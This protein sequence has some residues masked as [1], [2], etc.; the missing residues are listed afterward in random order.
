M[1]RDASPLDAQ[2]VNEIQIASGRSEVDLVRLIADPA[3]H[4]LVAECDDRVGGWAAIHYLPRSDGPAGRGHYL[5]GVTVDP[6]ERRRGV[7]LALTRA[8]LDW[9]WKRADVAWYFVNAQNTV[10]IALHESLGFEL[11]GGS[12]G[13]HGGEFTGGLGL[14]FRADRP[15]E[16]PTP[17]EGR[18]R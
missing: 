8:R 11:V 7:G 6:A 15:R 9:I 2:R 18:S 14:I 4:T 12:A 1:L 5:A 17:G 13:V 10:S 3:R 16:R